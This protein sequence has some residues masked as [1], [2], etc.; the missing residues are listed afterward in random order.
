MQRGSSYMRVK[1]HLPERRCSNTEEGE[2]ERWAEMG[3]WD[4]MIRMTIPTMT[5]YTCHLPLIATLSASWG[6]HRLTSLLYQSLLLSLSRYC[7][8]LVEDVCCVSQGITTDLFDLN[9]FC[10]ISFPWFSL[11]T[12]SFFSSFLLRITNIFWPVATEGNYF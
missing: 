12:L 9:L 7:F 1:R 3:E 11:I 5:Y 2:R 10:I 6:I 8:P 4:E